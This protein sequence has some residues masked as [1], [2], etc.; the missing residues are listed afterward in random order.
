MVEIDSRLLSIRVLAYIYNN[1]NV[2]DRGLKGVEFS[3]EELK[4]ATEK[5]LDKEL[6]EEL[7]RLYDA[8]KQFK[9][10]LLV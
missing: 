7:K 6:L 2:V 1:L 9:K 3:I 8:N 10:G 5:K 4:E